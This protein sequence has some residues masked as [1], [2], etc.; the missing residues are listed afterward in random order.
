MEITGNERLY[1]LHKSLLMRSALFMITTASK[2]QD[3]DRLSILWKE[4][5]DERNKSSRLLDFQEFGLLSIT[6]I[7][8]EK[9]ILS[10]FPE[11]LVND[12]FVHNLQK[13]SR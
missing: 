4:R 7:N 10:L 11:R 6:M 12:I 5:I 13:S 1:A 3:V 8:Y 2:E 9:I